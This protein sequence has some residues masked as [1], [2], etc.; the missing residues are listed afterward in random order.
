MGVL[1][2]AQSCSPHPHPDAGGRF[3]ARGREMRD[4]RGDAGQEMR[5]DAGQ[6]M[7]VC[8]CPA[9]VRLSRLGHSLQSEAHQQEYFLVPGNQIEP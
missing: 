8:P 5:V 6:E 7:R 9:S 3:R 2:D 4:R 1:S